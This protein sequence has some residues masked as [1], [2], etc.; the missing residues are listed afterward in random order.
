V[1]IR[2]KVWVEV[3]GRYVFGHGISEVLKAVQKTGSIKA[4]GPLVGRSYRHTWDR[5]KDAEQNLG[6]SLVETRVG[7]QGSDRSSLTP[8]AERLVEKFDL[9]RQKLIDWAERESDRGLNAL[10]VTD[11]PEK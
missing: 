11:P 3:D 1:K 9:L 6:R 2:V 10:T 4:A 8:L 5:I 7:G